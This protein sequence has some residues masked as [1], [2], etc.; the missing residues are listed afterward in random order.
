MI[1]FI[2]F[3]LGIA[4]GF[5]LFSKIFLADTKDDSLELNQK[6]SVIIPARNE[7][8]NLPYLLKS[9]FSQTTV[10]DEIIVVDDFSED[11]T[12]KIARKFGVK[13]IKNPPLPPG[14][15]GKN[16]ALWNGYLNSTGDI[17][18]F[19][20]ADVRLSKDGIE[21]IVK[22][23]FSTNGAISVIPYHKTEQFYERLCLIVNILSVFAF[24]SPYERKTR[25]K[26][27]YGSCIAVFR[28]DYEKVGGHKCIRDRV[29]DDLSLGKLFCENGIKVE[30]FLGLGAVTFRM[31]PNGMKS[32]LEGIAKSAA[33]SMQLLNTKTVFLIALWAFGLVL[34]GFLTPILLYIHHPLATKFLIGYILYVIQILYLQIYIGNFG[35]V[36]PILHFI[37]TA[38]FLLMLLYSFYQVKFIRSVYWKGRQ[39][40][41][42]GK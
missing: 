11:N 23:L 8:K 5:F 6:I 2:I 35:I 28:K 30:N 19:L 13:L 42:G 32:Q 24:M 34:T 29:T 40:K 41:V 21:R 15:T 10:P 20:D 1:F 33:L 25:S 4:S 16:W 38:Y 12:S 36:L 18:I 17:L 26:G 27:M 22:T 14:W 31:Y 39:I 3:I 9:L 37:P 7:E